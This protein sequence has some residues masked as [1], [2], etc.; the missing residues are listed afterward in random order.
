MLLFIKPS[1]YTGPG[2][3]YKREIR[4]AATFSAPANNKS[5]RSQNAQDLR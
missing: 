1:F 4:A 2:R 5:A 3:N